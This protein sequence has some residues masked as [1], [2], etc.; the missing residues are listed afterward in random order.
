MHFIDPEDHFEYE[1]RAEISGEDRE[2]RSVGRAEDLPED[3]ADDSE[4]R[5]KWGFP[6]RRLKP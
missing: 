1:D 3:E 4:V 2:V 5:A 6:P